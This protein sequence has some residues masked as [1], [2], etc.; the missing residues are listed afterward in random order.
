M[1]VT[2][3]YKVTVT[4]EHYYRTLLWQETFLFFLVTGLSIGNISKGKHIKYTYIFN[5]HLQL[6]LTVL[7][8]VQ[9]FKFSPELNKCNDLHVTINYI[10]H[11]YTNNSVLNVKQ[12]ITLS[13]CVFC[14]ENIGR[15]TT[16][17]HGS[18]KRWFSQSL[19]ILYTSLCWNYINSIPTQSSRFSW[20][21]T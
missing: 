3:H 21:N 19:N 14:Q 11:T 17:V 2:L 10:I 5:A 1:L 6:Y 12:H 7:N 4:T 9:I 20:N 18:S 16:L 8:T 13:L 15:S